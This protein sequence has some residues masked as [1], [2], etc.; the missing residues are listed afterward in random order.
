MRIV[1]TAFISLDG[2]VQA[3]GGPEEDTEGGFAHG[4]WTQPLF[5]AEVVGEAFD[6]A[7]EEADAL[8]FGRRTWQNMAGRGRSGRGTLPRKR[9]DPQPTG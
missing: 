9:G 2:V 6:A 8:L 3:L 5:D 1:I 7:L 4:G